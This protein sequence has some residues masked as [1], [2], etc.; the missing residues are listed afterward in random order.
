MAYIKENQ[1][2]F[3]NLC[4]KSSRLL[5]LWQKVNYIPRTTHIKNSGIFFCMK[6]LKINKVTLECS[7]LSISP[8]R[9]L[10]FFGKVC[11]CQIHHHPTLMSFLYF[12]LSLAR[13]HFTAKCNPFSNI[14]C[15]SIASSFFI[16]KVLNYKLGCFS[17]LLVSLIK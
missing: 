12:E 5:I 1:V 17:R 7:S 10:W 14:F 4:L 3:F 8:M 16:S 6:K 11:S 15:C 2:Y 13:R 9:D